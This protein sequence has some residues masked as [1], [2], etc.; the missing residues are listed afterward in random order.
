MKKILTAVTPQT[1]E[2]AR[3]NWSDGHGDHPLD[4]FLKRG[5]IPHIW[6]SGCGIGIVFTAFIKGLELSGI[7]LEKT[8]VV[9]GIGCSGRA[10]GYLNLD[11]YHT[12]HGRAIPFATG[13]KLANPDL[14]VIVFSGDGD[15]FAIGGN[16]IIHGARR[17]VDLTVICINNFNYG[18]TGGQGGPTTPLEAKTTTT[19]YGS[20][21]HP[22]NLIY[23]AKAAGAVYVSRW[24]VLHTYELR[25][26]IVEALK[27]PGFCF[28]EA[29]TPCHTGYARRNKLGS[30]LDVMRFYKDNSYQTDILDPENT[31][32]PF[33]G[34]VAVGNFVDTEKKTFLQMYRDSVLSRA[35]SGK[36]RAVAEEE[37]AAA[38]TATGGSD[39]QVRIAGFGGQGII[40][41]GLILGKAVA[42]FG[43][44]NATM[45]QSYGP[46]AR[47]GACSADV[48]V[49]PDRI[50]YPRVTEPDLLILMSEEAA[51]TYGAA[52]SENAEVLINS[53]LVK[54]VPRRRDLSVRTIPATRIAEDLGRV[55]VANIVMLGFI[56]STAGVVGYDSMKHAILDSIPKGTEEL[57]LQAFQA[58]FDWGE[59]A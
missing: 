48:V 51:R 21:E 36:V 56:C 16:H 3:K 35:E 54:T 53:D 5:R 20:S 49:S 26:S 50:N 39:G 1:A 33:K 40:L 31:A 9:S 38:V 44:A 8:V 41:A 4:R 19:P 45:T 29:I 59:K 14:N 52:C 7:D 10:A 46:E 42:L 18:M 55:I 34:R 11:T 58:G 30:A 23:L 25:D 17:N 43:G 32:L 2:Q 6:C 27:K 13:L 28:I 12:T 57:N 47:G 22:F 24:T 37:F 15:L